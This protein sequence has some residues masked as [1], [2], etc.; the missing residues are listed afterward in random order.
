MLVEFCT[1]SSILALAAFITGADSQSG[2]EIWPVPEWQE[3]KTETL[4]MSSEG[5]DAYI[6]W[7]SSKATGEPYGTIVIRCGKIVL[8][9]YGSGADRSSA[10]EIGSIRKAVGSSLLGMAI[11]EKRLTL[12]T[13]VYDIWPE[14]FLETG[15]DKDKAIRVRHLFNS[16]SGWK[17]PEPPETTWVYNNAAFTAGGMVLGRIYQLPE[18]RIAPIAKKRIADRIGASSWRCYHYPDGFSASN[19]NPGP[20]L[21]ID[22]NMRDLAR[23]GYLWLRQGEWNGE[24]I[25]PRGYVKEATQNQV[26][27][28]NGHYGFCWFVNDG[29][30]LLPNAPED[31]YFHIGN[32]KENRRTVIIIIPSL[33]L[34][35]VVGTHASMYDITSG[36]RSEPVPH[37]NE[38]IGNILL[39]LIGG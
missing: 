21:A 11:E 8:E 13:V 18:D 4:G 25:I 28:L 3:A 30:I 10:W 5:L 12:D 7:L 31:A 15:E 36:Y 6:F 34:V 33:D 26:A 16:S 32:G 1:V 22:S 9:H 20:K 19:G 38:W 27:H 24:Q 23:F 39:T 29:K 14:I 35:A 2:V 17:R 37:V